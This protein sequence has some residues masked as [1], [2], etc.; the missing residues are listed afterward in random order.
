M[1]SSKNTR[2]PHHEDIRQYLSHLCLLWSRCSLLFL[3][4]HLPLWYPRHPRH[5][6]PLQSH[7]PVFPQYSGCKL[8]TFCLEFC[9]LPQ[10]QETSRYICLINSFQLS[11][12]EVRVAMPYPYKAEYKYQSDQ[13]NAL[14]N[15]SGQ[16]VRI[17]D[18]SFPH[19][20]GSSIL[21]HRGQLG[22]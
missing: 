9:I 13:D 14:L 21:I 4:P 1:V 22:I 2:N 5:L 6:Y 8:S 18:I 16:D 3:L 11:Q 17:S 10:R 7:A 20:H 15:H 19:L 12:L